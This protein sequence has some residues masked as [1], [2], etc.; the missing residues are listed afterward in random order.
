MNLKN[1]KECCFQH[2]CWNV[3]LAENGNCTVQMDDV[4]ECF[5]DVEDMGDLTKCH[6]PES[7]QDIMFHL[8]RKW[9]DEYPCNVC[10][11]KPCLTEVIPQW[12]K[13]KGLKYPRGEVK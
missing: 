13:R 7:E 11:D 6:M 10:T 4:L 8:Y 9:D 2:R 12:E 3:S 1:P 5:V